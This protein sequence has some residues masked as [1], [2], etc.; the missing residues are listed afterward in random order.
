M[1]F[2]KRLAIWSKRTFNSSISNDFGFRL[3]AVDVNGTSKPNVIDP[4]DD[5]MPPDVLTFMIMDNGE[6]YPLGVAADNL[7]V[8]GNKHIIC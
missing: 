5:K 3:L 2:F 8:A 4:D 6:M 1:S 7:K